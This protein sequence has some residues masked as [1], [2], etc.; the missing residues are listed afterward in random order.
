MSYSSYATK[1]ID[2]KN[3]INNISISISNID[4]DTIWEGKAHNKQKE[5]IKKINSDINTQS[6]NAEHLSN[7]LTSIDKYE[8]IKKDIKNLQ[9]QLDN[10]DED[11]KDYSSKANEIR[12]EIEKKENEKNELK[13]KIDGLLNKISTKYTNQLIIISKP[14]LINTQ[15]ILNE[16]K[17]IGTSL[18][19]SFKIIATKT[20]Q[21]QPIETTPKTKNSS[22]NSGSITINNKGTKYDTEPIPGKQAQRINVYH[23]DTRLYDDAEITIKKGETIRLTMNITENCG[24]IE[25]LTR[26]SS[27][28]QSN[29]KNYISAHSEPFIKRDDPSTY[30][31]ISSYD[32]VI[33]GNQVTNG[34][35]ILSQTT[36]H[37]TQSGSY[38]SMY[39]IKVNVEN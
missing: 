19:N 3:K 35:I 10:L 31:N 23:N 2:A 30:Q 32:W 14:E 29:W 9:N 16:A 24:D 15:N 39:T 8:Q 37:Q 18:V 21:K 5:N 28:G 11:D 13:S 17:I 25:L 20:Q 36:Q 4:I 33:T 7:A 1:I 27:D 38:K 26:T 6:N 34:H 12:I 22:K